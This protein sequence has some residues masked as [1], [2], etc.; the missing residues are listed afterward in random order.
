MKRVGNLLPRIAEVTNLRDAYYKAALA[1]RHLPVVQAFAARLDDELQQLAEDLLA[2][3]VAVGHYA[4]FVVHDP[5]QRVIHAASFRERVLHHAIMNICG[6]YFERGAID[7]S[8][9]CRRGKGN[10]AALRLATVYAARYRYWMRLDMRKYFDSIHQQVLQTQYRRL[11]K[12]EVVLRLLDRIV[13]SYHTSDGCG[14]PI[15]TLTSQYLANYYLDVFDHFV[16]ETLCCHGYIRF[17]DDMAFWHDDRAVLRASYARVEEFLH[18]VLALT[19]KPGARVLPTRDGM[20]FLGVRVLPGTLLLGGRA[21]S[22]YRH[23]VQAYAELW[24]QGLM[25]DAEYQQRLTALTA[26]V[27]QAR[28]TA[29]RQ[30]VLAGADS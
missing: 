17:M 15:G 8:F 20:L 14:L 19:V 3:D 21:R 4:R 24:Q 16:Q 23:K 7:Q 26:F 9:A 2:G 5:K 28:C 6:A 29:W 12:D 25:S 1:H 10:T 13:A 22:R 30:R 27:T 11:F 18:R